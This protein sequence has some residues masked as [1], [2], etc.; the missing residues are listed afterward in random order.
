MST[1]QPKS[2]VLRPKAGVRALCVAL[3][4]AGVVLLMVHLPFN[5]PDHHRVWIVPCF[6]VLGAFWLADVFLTR[7]VL[8]S[9]SLRIVSISDLLCG[10]THV[11]PTP[12][13]TRQT[14][15]HEV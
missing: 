9:D 13:G 15:C 14:S 6:A 7:I 5:I 4:L 3:Y 8:A 10:T 1:L 11:H 12:M 2:Q